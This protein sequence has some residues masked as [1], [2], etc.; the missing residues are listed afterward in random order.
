M[1]ISTRC[2]ESTLS[3]SGKA[4]LIYAIS[5][6]MGLSGTKVMSTQFLGL[7]ISGSESKWLKLYPEQPLQWGRGPPYWS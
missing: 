7:T 3:T 5:R 1:V 6:M 4:W 2:P